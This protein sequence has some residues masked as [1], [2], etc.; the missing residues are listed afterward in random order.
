M[1]DFCSVGT[2]SLLDYRQSLRKITAKEKKILVL[3]ALDI[4][5]GAVNWFKHFATRHLF[6][7]MQRGVLAFSSCTPIIGRWQVTRWGRGYQSGG[8]VGKVGR[9]AVMLAS[10]EE[11]SRCE[12]KLFQS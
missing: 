3:L 1:K 5:E 9:P 8:V 2:S 11:S 10:V 7:V 12:N 6:F 4:T